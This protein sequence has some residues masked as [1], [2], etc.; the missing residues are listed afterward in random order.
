M[1]PSLLVAV[2]VVAG[3]AG[4][5]D[6]GPP[7][8]PPPTVGSIRGVVVTEAI[9]T[10]PGANV[11]LAG[12]QTAVT[13]LAGVFHFGNLT[14]GLYVLDAEAPTYLAR[15]TTVEVQAGNVTE[16]RF[17]LPVN[18][19]ALAFHQTFSFKGFA[20]LHGGSNSPELGAC[21]CDFDVPLDGPWLT[22]IVE[23]EWEDVVSP[24][25]FETEFAWGVAAGPVAA[26]GTGPSPLLGRLE[27]GDSAV[28]AS[29]AAVR[30]APASDWLFA[31]QSFDVLVTVWYGE[32]APAGFQALAG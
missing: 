14:P 20:E 28:S 13:D 27:A 9:T 16:V 10:I 17:V 4:C 8:T 22:I 3:L 25:A 21:Q 29:N 23:A 1:R 30:V 19:S 6:D 7:P 31:S 2:L 26:N 15:Q 5:S 11:T 12:N 32:T 24:V 18:T